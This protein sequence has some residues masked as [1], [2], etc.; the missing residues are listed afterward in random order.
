MSTLQ[1]FLGIVFGEVRFSLGVLSTVFSCTG[2]ALGTSVFLK[3]NAPKNFKVFRRM[4]FR[5]FDELWRAYNYRADLIIKF[6]L[7]VSYRDS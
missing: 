6:F 4:P 7:V 5:V 3:I 2:T 1:I